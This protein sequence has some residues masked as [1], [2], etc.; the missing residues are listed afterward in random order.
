[1]KRSPIAPVALAAAALVALAA[2]PA[3]AGPRVVSLDQCADQYVLALAAPGDI[4]GLSY[5]ADDADSELRAD[6]PKGAPLM[7]ADLESVLAA[8]PDVVVR[9]WGGDEL[10]VRRLEA[11]GVRVVKIDEAT[12]FDGVRADVRRVAAALGDPAGGARLIAAMDRKL[13]AA[14]GAW[15][16]RRALYLT[17][18]GYTAGARTLVGAMLQAA[19]LV[20]AAAAPGYGPV[21]LEALVLDPPAALVLGFFDPASLQA[22]WWSMGRTEAVRRLVEPRTVASLPGAILGCPAWFAADGAEELSST[23]ERGRWPV[24]PEGASRRATPAPPPSL[25]DTSTVQR[26]RRG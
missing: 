17:P 20:P 11:R 12:D 14:Q 4:A 15:G 1:V 10:M 9:Y 24:R 26:G 5:R 18:G 3:A 2:G 13:Q 21:R 23:A 22:Q 8:R 25:R 19:G 16:G 6:L 7:R